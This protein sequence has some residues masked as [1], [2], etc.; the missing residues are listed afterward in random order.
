MLFVGMNGYS[1]SK[2]FRSFSKSIDDKVS[3]KLP[4]QLLNAFHFG[5][6][7]SQLP[8]ILPIDP[9][10]ACTGITP[11]W[12]HIKS[13][14][15]NFPVLQGARLTVKCI[16]KYVNLGAEEV[17]CDRGTKYQGQPRCVKLG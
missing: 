17:T 11:S 15:F 1:G 14:N 7:E 12:Q 6:T 16:R 5:Y 13:D 4:L 9:F 10:T 8:T 2:L 3:K